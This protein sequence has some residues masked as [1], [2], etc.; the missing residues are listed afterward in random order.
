MLC[1][2]CGTIPVEDA[3]FCAT[4]GSKLQTVQP[5]APSAVPVQSKYKQIITILLITVL[6]MIVMSGCDSNK[7][8]YEHA[9][10]LLSNGS[11]EEAAA[12]FDA[13]GEYKDAAEKADEAR[14]EARNQEYQSLYNSADDFVKQGE[15]DLALEVFEELGDFSDAQDR[16]DEAKEAKRK[17]RYDEAAALKGTGEYEQA[18][19]IFAELGDYMDSAAM[20]LSCENLVEEIKNY[21]NA[22]TVFASGSYEYASELFQTLPQGYENT[23]SYISAMAAI[24]VFNAEEW[25]DAVKAFDLLM[26]TPAPQDEAR[27]F[28]TFDAEEYYYKSLC[29]YY[30]EH[31][32]LGE[33]ITQLSEYPYPQ[34]VFTPSRLK[35]LRDQRIKRIE[36]WIWDQQVGAYYHNS[37][38]YRDGKCPVEVIGYGLYMYDLNYRGGTALLNI[39]GEILNK[40]NPFYIAETPE[41][42]RYILNISERFDEVGYYTNA[43]TA[44]KTYSNVTITDAITDQVLSK[45]TFSAEPPQTISH[46]GD[47]YG[48]PNYSEI[49]QSYIL[50]EL[51]NLISGCTR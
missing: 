24:E 3:A 46:Y 51:E 11:Y 5:A 45:W 39:T 33:D 29:E 41:S 7:E 31:A 21:D 43:G 26:E 13:L 2:N 44:W 16:A 48:I 19:T 32:K 14:K 50:P 20:V 18:I 35:E 8:S 10:T 9:V 17:Q 38:E 47:G 34:P 40:T 49:I 15:Y 22:R 37:P 36:D 30:D 23:R 1:T 27:F 42:A 12:T 25:L 4:C 6:F 28:Q